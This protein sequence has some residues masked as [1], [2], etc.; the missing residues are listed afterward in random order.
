M[1]TADKE[2]KEAKKNGVKDGSNMLVPRSV[3]I[4]NLGNTCFF[5]SVMQCLMNTQPLLLYFKRI[6]S[7]SFIT[8]P[9]EYSTKVHEVEVKV[10]AA[11]IPLPDVMMPLVKT[12]HN[13]AGEYRTSDY[14]TNPRGLFDQIARKATRFRGWQQQDAHE[15]LRYLLD[16]LRQEEIGRFKRAFHSYYEIESDIAL[17]KEQTLLCKAFVEGPA[18]PILDAVFGGVLQQT[19]VCSKCHHVSVTFE[20]F[21]DLSLPLLKARNAIAESEF[22]IGSDFKNDK[23]SK[24]QQKKDKR[25]NSKKKKLKKGI[26]NRNKSVD[27]DEPEETVNVPE[28]GLAEENDANYYCQDEEETDEKLDDKMSVDETLLTESA[29]YSSD[30]AS[31]F[32]EMDNS[33]YDAS[34]FRWPVP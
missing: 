14:G 16:G 1:T 18:K 26:Q 30:H 25:K 7:T 3:G 29:S 9:V 28:G 10:P 20:P 21:L 24:H 19:I 33:E 13:F 17:D 34:R 12:F 5:N 23:P 27:A 8:N 32:K 4:P 2:A 22:G 11:E 15:L 31:V 6:K